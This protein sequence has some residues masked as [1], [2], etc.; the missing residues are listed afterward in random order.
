MGTKV[1][2][3]KPDTLSEDDK[4]QV[5]I[6]DLQAK[7]QRFVHLYLTGQ[8]K[9]AKLAELL[10]VSYNTVRYWLKDERISTIIAN[11]QQEEHELVDV[12]IKNLRL[13]AITKIGDL[14]DDP[15][16]GVALQACKDI[17][18]RSGHKAIQKVEKNV[19]VTTYEQQMRELI[20]STIIDVDYEEQEG[21]E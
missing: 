8:Y 16:S 1:Q 15:V 3:Q 7:Q 6:T 9:L 13:K 5:V 2:V 14:V 20:D 19:T 21:E 11:S 17:L 12:A 10:G 4:Q 18:D